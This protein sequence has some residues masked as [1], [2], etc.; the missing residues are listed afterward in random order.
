MLAEAAASNSAS[1]MTWKTQFE[2]EMPL[3]IVSGL[4]AASAAIQL[5]SSKSRRALFALACPQ[6]EGGGGRLPR[7][8]N[9]FAVCSAARLSWKDVFVSQ[10]QMWSGRRG[11]RVWHDHRNRFET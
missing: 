4:E 3:D 2:S 11:G 6:R 10:A 5:Q 7:E 8:T 1:C 9:D